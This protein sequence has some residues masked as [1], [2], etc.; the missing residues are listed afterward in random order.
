MP[1]RKTVTEQ[2]EEVARQL[3]LTPEMPGQ[4]PQ[5]IDGDII[6]QKELGA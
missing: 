1:Q 2:A 3:G 6:D 5:I 4:D